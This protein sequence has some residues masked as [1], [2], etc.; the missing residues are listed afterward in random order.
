MVLFLFFPWQPVLFSRTWLRQRSLLHPQPLCVFLCAG[1]CL[2]FAP[3]HLLK[4]LPL[5]RR[6]AHCSH[7]NPGCKITSRHLRIWL[8]FNKGTLKELEQ[9]SKQTFVD[10]WVLWRRVGSFCE[11]T[12]A[13]L[14]RLFYPSFVRLFEKKWPWG[15]MHFNVQT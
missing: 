9:H 11:H 3:V 5:K 1:L 4:Q 12:M 10:S 6:K 13:A 7:V 15:N 14:R 8:D 2:F